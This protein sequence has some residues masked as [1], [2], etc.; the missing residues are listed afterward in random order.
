MEFSINICWF[1]WLCHQL[2]PGNWS[3]FTISLLTSLKLLSFWLQSVCSWCSWLINNSEWVCTGVDQFTL[4]W[5][6]S[7]L[8]LHRRLRR[9]PGRLEVR[10]EFVLQRVKPEWTERTKS[11]FGHRGSVCNT[12]EV[13]QQTIYIVVSDC[14]L[15]RVR[16]AQTGFTNTVGQ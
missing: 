12:G 13:K 7:S 16:A 9:A 11:V 1:F 15:E 2:V 8:F 4:W 6:S 10:L 14:S 5:W 3:F